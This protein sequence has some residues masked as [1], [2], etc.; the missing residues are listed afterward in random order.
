MRGV[1]WL[2][3]ATVGSVAFQVTVSIWPQKFAHY[4]W[5]VPYVWMVWGVVLL[6]LLITHEKI[7][8]RKL[9]KW[10]GIEEQASELPSPLS[11]PIHNENRPH[12]EFN[13]H[14]EVNPNFGSAQPQKQPQPLERPKAEPQPK[15]G[16]NLAFVG[17]ETVHLS[18][19]LYGGFFRSNDEREPLA[20]IG[21]FGK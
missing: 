11:S 10:W 16:P 6:S 2:I 3:G 4:A 20:Q 5:L 7:L 12:F 17:T 18:E 13:P 15:P 1:L 19:G 9:K 8:G 14:I 21:G